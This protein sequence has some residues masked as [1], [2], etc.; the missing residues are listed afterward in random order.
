M[1]KRLFAVLALAILAISSALSGAEVRLTA[2][3]LQPG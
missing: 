2:L 3:T 1:S